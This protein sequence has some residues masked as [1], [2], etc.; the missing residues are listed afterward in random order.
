MNLI[1]LSIPLVLI[2]AVYY[3]VE[4]KEYHVNSNGIVL[5]T[6]AS[7]GIGNHAA[8]HLAQKYPN[9][10]IFAGVRKQDDITK[11][12]GL[13]IKNLKDTQI[14]FIGLVNNAGIATQLPL[15]LHQLDDIKSLFNVN[16]FSIIDLI[17]LTLPLLRQTKG[18][19][20]NMSSVAGFGSKRLSGVYSSSKFALESLSDA[21]RQ[22]VSHM[23]ISVSV[24]EPA[25]VKTSIAENAKLSNAQIIFQNELKNKNSAA[26]LYSD[27][28]RKEGL[29]SIA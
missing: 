4:R 16:V 8:I 20:I 29:K 3:F 21:L 12:E 15:E 1:L 19:I 11:I 22:E 24:I 25:Y 28:Y 7:S 13:K 27:M 9:L 18:R 23:G 6:G 26:N 17:Q 5:I 10:Q 2:L 14:P